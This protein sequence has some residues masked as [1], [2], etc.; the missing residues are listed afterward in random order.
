[1]EATA[2]AETVSDRTEAD[3]EGAEDATRAVLTT[4]GERL[5]EDQARDLAAQLPGEYADPLT[6]GEAG[7]R[8]SEE[9]FISRVDQRLD[10]LEISGDRAATAVLGTILEAVDEDE[11]AAVVDQFEHYGFEELLSETDADVDV[12]E[13]SPRER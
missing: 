11:R 12:S 1:M 8:F 6:E 2:I 4:L 5:G 7:Q 10:T 13:R 9:E 3:E